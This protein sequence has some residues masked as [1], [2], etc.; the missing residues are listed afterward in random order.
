[1]KAAPRLGAIFLTVFVDLLGFGLVLP[2]LAKEARDTFGVSEFVAT[3][4]GSVYSLMQFLF[5]PIWGR[6]SDRVG[7]RPV[8]LWSIAGTAVAMAA[9]GA[10]LAWGTSVVWLFAARVFGGIA[11][12]NLGTAS[13]YIADITKPEERAKGMGLIGA[14]FGLGFILG[15]GIGGA[16]AKITVGGRHGALPCFVA[17][18]LSVINVV[19][20]ALGVA[21]SLPPERRARVPARRLVPL[22]MQAVREAFALPGVAL[23]VAVNFIVVVS[24]TNLD[25]TFTFFC[26]DLFGIDERG[27]GYVL[28]FIGVVA[29]AVQGGLV[30]PLSKRFDEP[31][32]LRAGT[33]VQA[34]AFAGLVLAGGR[35]A[36]ALLYGSGALLALG[37]GLT[38][39][40][41]AAFISRRAPP[42]RQGGTL[43]TN[44]SFASLARTFGPAVG[45]FLYGSGPRVP[46]AAASVGMLVALALAMGLQ[47]EGGRAVT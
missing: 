44:Q 15:P 2:F 37:N 11:T 38:Q 14:A 8:L 16:L 12:A 24:F 47:R 30:R 6:V 7:R 19:W 26:A 25:Q 42:E 20:V 21:E 46:Y 9:L 28:A 36:R 13:A 18:C 23:A 34:L 22:N 4:L 35:G 29:A 5:V 45:G 33:L 3:L 32:L 39:P 43:G 41:T 40:S 27:T 31:T 10:G 1:M 17:A